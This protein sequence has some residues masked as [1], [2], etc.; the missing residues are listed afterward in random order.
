MNYPKQVMTMT[1]LTNMGISESFLRRAYA[2]K[3]ETI[4][5]KSD[6]MK[7]NSPILFDTEALEKYRLRQ[8]TAEK[9]AMSM[10]A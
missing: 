2:A 9:K 4:A 1:A 7:T 5:W 3:D 8:I 6:P 10:M